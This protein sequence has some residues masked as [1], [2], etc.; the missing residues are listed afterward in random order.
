[1]IFSCCALRFCAL[2][3]RLRPRRPPG[4]VLLRLRQA[5]GARAQRPEQR[6]ASRR[7]RSRTRSRARAAVALRLLLVLLARSK[8]CLE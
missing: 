8:E 7:R 5:R 4:G 3:R 6:G 2:L 1:M